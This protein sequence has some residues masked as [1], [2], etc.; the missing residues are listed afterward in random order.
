MVWTSKH[1]SGTSEHVCAG[2]AVNWIL[3]WYVP[4]GILVSCWNSTF[5]PYNVHAGNKAI[6]II[7]IVC[8][9]TELLRFINAM[10]NDYII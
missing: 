7:V 6:F 3:K 8:I 9:F 10:P 1:V 5:G 2:G 4:K